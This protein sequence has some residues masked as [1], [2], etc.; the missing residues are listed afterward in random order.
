MS[1][2]SITFTGGDALERKLLEL[3]HRLGKSETLRVGFLEGGTYKD[4]TSVP[5]VA[6]IQEYGSPQRN[7][8]SRPYFRNMINEKS[9]GWANAITKAL[10]S[11]NY[12]A[13]DALRIMGEGIANQLKES[14]RR[15]DS[16]P[17]SPV[18]IAKKGFD[19]QLIDTGVMR[20]S[21]DYEIVDA[22]K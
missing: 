10:Q 8:P 21:V 3:A 15:F 4:G 12:N 7:I 5:M 2:K 16:V 6:A 18:T 13:E 20:D 19:K 22:D 1:D 11:T 9:P 17:L 14:I